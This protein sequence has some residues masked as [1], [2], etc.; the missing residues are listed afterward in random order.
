MMW[1]AIAEEA[2][3]RQWIKNLV[4]LA[5]LVFSGQLTDGSAVLGAAVA[6]VG[7]CLLSSGVYF[8]NDIHD[9]HHDRHNP[10]KAHRP[11]ASG[12]LS[13]NVAELVAALLMC[14]GMG[15]LSLLGWRCGVVAGIYLLMSLLYCVRLKH[16]VIVDVM[17]ISL[18]F[19][20]RMLAGVFAVGALPTAWIVLCMF[21]LSLF[22]GF[23]KRRGELANRRGAARRG[24]PVLADYSLPLLDLLLAMTATMAVVCYALYTVTGRD[25]PALV[26]T[27]PLVVYGVVRYMLLVMVRNRGELPDELLVHDRMLHGAVA[28][29]ALVCAAVLYGK[30]EFLNWKV[31]VGRETV[32]STTGASAMASE[33]AELRRQNRLLRGLLESVGTTTRSGRGILADRDL[34]SMFDETGL[35][36]D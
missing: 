16:T 19:V 25:T 22:L 20:L 4:C 10:L 21:F 30:V 14:G 23:A 15:V 3:P 34:P 29:W 36:D 9:R 26:V 27:I 32:A 11:I 31:P 18:G 35:P 1:S 7:F 17:C 13:V 12:R 6:F 33:I 2:R 28:A 24:R 8:V 5:G